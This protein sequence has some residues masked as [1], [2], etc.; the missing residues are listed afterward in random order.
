MLLLL[1][2]GVPSLEW[3]SALVGAGL[4]LGVLWGAWLGRYTAT[5]TAPDAPE[6]DPFDYQSIRYE[7]KPT[8]SR[9]EN[10]R[11]ERMD[12]ARLPEK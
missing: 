5:I 4:L 1:S 10:L 2:S 11:R 6:E 8:V 9:S 3:A 7:R 12:L